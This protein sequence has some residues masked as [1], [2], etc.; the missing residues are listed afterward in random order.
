MW[1]VFMSHFEI[2]ALAK[3]EERDEEPRT[4]FYGYKRKYSLSLF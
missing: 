1:V 4:F 3:N 2:G